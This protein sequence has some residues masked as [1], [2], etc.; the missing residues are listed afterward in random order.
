MFATYL[1]LDQIP[2]PSALSHIHTAQFTNSGSNQQA[3]VPT[4]L[5]ELLSQPSPQR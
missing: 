5:L 4:T 3:N 2:P 1:V